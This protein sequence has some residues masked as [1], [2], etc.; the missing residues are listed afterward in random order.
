MHCLIGSIIAQPTVNWHEVLFVEQKPPSESS[1]PLTFTASG[2]RSLSQVLQLSPAPNPTILTL[3]GHAIDTIAAIAPALIPPPLLP[4]T[5]NAWAN[6]TRADLL[7]HHLPAILAFLAHLATYLHTLHAWHRFALHHPRTNE[8]SSSPSPPFLAHIDTITAAVAAANPS[9]DT[10]TD[11]ATL[12]HNH[13]AFRTA[14]R[15]ARAFVGRDLSSIIPVGLATLATLDNMHCPDERERNAVAE[16]AT[17]A[18]KRAVWAGRW[19]SV[20]GVFCARKRSAAGA[21][22]G[23][24][25]W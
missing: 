21:G 18:A 20:V 13:A 23:V 25:G 19:R 22:E 14:Q 11:T 9:P 12:Q 2:N 24:G 1:E 4:S 3:T 8:P 16:A 10:N 15:R 17:K 6:A 7:A 5:L